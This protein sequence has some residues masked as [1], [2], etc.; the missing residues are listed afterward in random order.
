VRL[1]LIRPRTGRSFKNLQKNS[2][3]GRCWLKADGPRP[4]CSA[5]N[6]LVWRATAG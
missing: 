6:P 3:G 1:L 5:Q 4:R 2:L